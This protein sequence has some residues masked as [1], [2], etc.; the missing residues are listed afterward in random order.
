MQ[1]NRGINYQ[2]ISHHYQT[3]VAP[4]ERLTDEVRTTFE[5]DMTTARDLAREDVR[6]FREYR[7]FITTWIVYHVHVGMILVS[8]GYTV[9]TAL[10]RASMQHTMFSPCL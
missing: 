9:R 6:P 10:E 3:N 4:G 8:V 2:A 7:I 5:G 1:R